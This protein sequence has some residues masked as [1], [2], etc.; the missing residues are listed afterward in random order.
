MRCTNGAGRRRGSEADCETVLLSVSACYS[1]DWDADAK[2]VDDET[3]DGE[4]EVEVWHANVRE[5]K[6]DVLHEEVDDG[7]PDRGGQDEVAIQE[8][9]HPCEGEVDGRRAE[10][11]DEMADETERGGFGSAC[12]GGLAAEDSSGDA[13]EQSHGSRRNHRAVDDERGG[14]VATAG[15]ESRKQDGFP[16]RVGGRHAEQVT[17]FAV[18]AEENAL[19]AFQWLLRK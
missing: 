5:G 14:D 17:L 4:L 8:R 11:D 6:Y 15:G 12:V 7:A 3:D 18:S 9:E 2:E 19:A 13:L 16:G 1:G 10:R